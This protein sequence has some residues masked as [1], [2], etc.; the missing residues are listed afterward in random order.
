[1][2]S[3]GLHIVDGDS[4][5][6][7]LRES[8]FN[9]S[10]HI[11]SWRDALYSGPVP[12]DLTL[13]R[14]SRLRSLFWSSGKRKTEFDVRDARIAK[15]LD[16]D[17]IILW[18]GLECTLCQLSLIQLLSWFKTQNEAP[19]H[20]TWVK[21]HGGT[22]RRPEV[23]HAYA[24]REFVN[25]QQMRLAAR[26]WHAFRSPSPLG[27]SRLL[28]SDLSALPGIRN[29]VRWILS[30]YPAKRDGLSRLQRKLLREIEV[31]ETAKAGEIVG[32][33]LMKESVGDLLL[34][35]FVEQYIQ[36]PYPLVNVVEPTRNRRLS[37]RS[38]V[39]LTDTGRDVLAGRADYISLNGVDRWIGG[40]HLRGHRV[41]WRW[42]PRRQRVI[43]LR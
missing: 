11:L 18:F 2:P 41:N 36:A 29:T 27:L 12:E 5:G 20:L 3:R 40:V 17:E 6:G 38:Q 37:Y 9:K 34:F 39:A 33:V 21:Q 26:V 15:Y 14:L 8:G 31:R 10:G 35:E 42:D 13:R 43:T 25:S 23:A 30:E 4:T 1:M 16:Y 22:L 24:C 7:T 28:D 32:A 19:L